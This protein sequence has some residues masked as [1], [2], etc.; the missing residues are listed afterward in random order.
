MTKSPLNVPSKIDVTLDMSEGLE[1]YYCGFQQA[2]LLLG[3]A[4]GLRV[5]ELSQ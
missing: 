3:V 2:L 4:F 1:S 5:A